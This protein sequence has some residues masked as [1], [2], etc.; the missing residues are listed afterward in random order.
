[1]MN[2]LFLLVDT[3]NTDI[4]IVNITDL[5]L[6]ISQK[7]D[8]YYW[9]LKEEDES[10]T[11][12]EVTSDSEGEGS[13]RKGV[14]DPTIAVIRLDTGQGDHG[15]DGD[16]HDGGR[17]AGGQPGLIA[18]LSV[19]FQSTPERKEKKYSELDQLE[20]ELLAAR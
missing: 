15:W 11:E 14:N 8:L 20:A 17:H 10:Q 19:L 7:G 16:C 6:V 13:P 12:T 2:T 4:S 9:F 5:W 3:E 18:L 1:M